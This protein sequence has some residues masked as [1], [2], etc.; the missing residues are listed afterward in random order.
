MSAEAW[1]YFSAI[2][3]FEDFL[4]SLRIPIGVVSLHFARSASLEQ[5]FANFS[6]QAPLFF[7]NCEIYKSLGRLCKSSSIL[8]AV[9]LGSD[10]SIWPQ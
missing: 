2:D 3:P 7:I 8:T 6:S 5:R 4:L 10:A 9:Y 1:A